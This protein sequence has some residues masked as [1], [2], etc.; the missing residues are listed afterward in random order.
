MRKRLLDNQQRAALLDKLFK[1]ISGLDDAS[2]I[3][4]NERLEQGHEA[5]MPAPTPL[6][7]DEPRPVQAAAP[8]PQ[9]PFVPAPVR[10]ADTQPA[11]PVST[12][13]VTRREFGSYVLVGSATAAAS[14]ISGYLLGNATVP[15]RIIQIV[16]NNDATLPPLPTPEDTLPPEVREQ[17]TTMQ[18][19]L[20][21]TRSERDE[22]NQQN[23]Q[24]RDDFDTLTQ[25]YE[26]MTARLATCER[27]L[28]LYITL[29][30]TGLDNLLNNQLGITEEAVTGV[31]S[32]RLKLAADVLDARALLERFENQE[33]PRM[34]ESVDWLQN[35][36]DSV[37]V[38]LQQLENA[39]APSGDTLTGIRDF[40]DALLAALPLG[41][42]TDLRAGLQAIGLILSSIPELVAQAN[43][44]VI[45]PMRLWVGGESGGGLGDTLVRPLRDGLVTTAEQTATA[46]GT[47]DRAYN[48]SFMPQ[49]EAIMQERSLIYLQIES[50]NR[51]TP[52]PATP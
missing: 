29:E 9:T 30:N 49:M 31:T 26:D 28:A 34:R 43:D 6:P 35:Q 16:P 52:M 24:L 39:L 44:L 15:E 13:H 51:I 36:L 47:L 41:L 20:Q 5:E 21:Q 37:A 50:A 2:L 11:R 12:R 10:R 22:L 19:A 14:I 17:I 23:I 33:I 42:G 18:D 7:F 48:E 45:D 4:L 46:S 25:Q 32:L 3:E 40:M 8:T 27:L 38:G 1:Q